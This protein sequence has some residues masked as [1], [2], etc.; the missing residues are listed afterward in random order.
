MKRSKIK[1]S[2]APKKTFA[3]VKLVLVKW[4][5]AAHQADESETIG[6]LLAWTVGFFMY[7]NEKEIAVC[8]DVFEDGDKQEILAIP[9]GMVKS[10]RTLAILPITSE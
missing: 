3:K 4:E 7:R 6:T 10:V 8:R 2:A 5:D 1:K 9:A